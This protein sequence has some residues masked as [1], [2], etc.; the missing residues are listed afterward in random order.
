MAKEG[1]RMRRA[2]L[3][4][5]AM[6]AVLV[7]AAPA[8]A[9]DG[10]PYVRSCL[11]VHDATG[12]TTVAALHD[13]PH[14]IAASPDGRQLYVATTAGALQ[15]IDRDPATGALTPGAD[16]AAPHSVAGAYDLVISHDGGTLLVS[17]NGLVLA[18]ARGGDGS[19]T[20][21]GCAGSAPGCEPMQGTPYGVAFSPDDRFVYARTTGGL[22]ALRRD[23]TQVACYTDAPTNGCDDLAA[24]GGQGTIAVTPDVVAVPFFTFNGA[25][26]P[27]GGVAVLDRHADGTLTQRTGTSGGCVSA[28]GKLDG[29]ANQCKVGDASL[30][31]AS[32][33]AIPPDARFVYVGSGSFVTVVPLA[34][35]G[36]L[37]TPVGS[38]AVG[39][40]L[41][42][43][44]TSDALVV[45]SFGG[46][47]RY[48][49]AGSTTP[50]G[51]MNSD[52]SNGCQ[53]LGG[54]AGDRNNETRLAAD[55]AGLNVYATGEQRGMLASIVRDYAPVCHAI[56]VAV[57]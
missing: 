28:G 46:A 7:R 54:L 57:P 17:A 13:A 44:A 14:Q 23:L 49:G 48:F 22:D 2:L 8:R 55:P 40:V 20:Y 30:T 25:G 27:G 4:M 39:T 36:A 52:G 29:V 53:A 16:A 33:A 56:S 26:G 37:Q 18:Y 1:A 45:S 5:A 47:I 50:G 51:C 32:V 42:L 6:A 24:L 10:D 15:T 43:V 19:L 11:V 35:G 34:Q 12:C 38:A 3:G 31:S 21:A 41:D 9:A